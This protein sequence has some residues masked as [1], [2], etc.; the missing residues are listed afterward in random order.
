MLQLALCYSCQTRE[1][2]VLSNPSA[3]GGLI[4]TELERTVSLSCMASASVTEELQWLRNGALVAL[5]EDN[6]QNQSSL[7]IQPIS[8]EDN[9]VVFTC[10]LKGDASVNASIE[11]EVIYA[12]EL[13]GMEE[14][15][16]EEEGDLML[17]CDVRAHPPVTV[18][19]MKDA[20][21]LDLS[22]GGFVAT[23][24]G[25]TA[26]LYVSKIERGLHQGQFS[27]EANS[28]IHGT[29]VKSFKI[30]VEDKTMKFPLEPI[31]AG[32]VVVCLTILLAVVSRWD[33]IMKC[34]K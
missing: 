33:R 25:V 11:L 22:S 9:T 2:T 16:V 3:N 6:R 14:I 21:I 20:A 13:S 1:L 7:C 8:R 10:Q 28:T 5:H 15:T 19:W 26:Q 23:N 29:R 32:I 4:R 17:S 34:C 31:I 24:D 27:C 30:T 18:T 12:P